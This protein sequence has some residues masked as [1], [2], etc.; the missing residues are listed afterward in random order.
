MSDAVVFSGVSC[1]DED[2]LALFAG[3][4]FAVAA[5]ESLLLAGTASSGKSA[6]LAL[7][8]GGVAPAAGTVEVLGLRPAELPPPELD[9][10]RMRIGYVP[11]RGGLLSN[12]S[13]RDNI[14]LP[15]RYHHD[16]NPAVAEAAIERVHT[17]LDV[18]LLPAVMPADAPLLMRQVAAIARA[19]VLG[20]E[21]LL[22][23]EPGSG[24]DEANAEE[25]WRLLWRVQSETG[26]A[27]LATAADAA[28]ARPLTDRVLHLA[29]RRRVTFRLM[30]GL[31]D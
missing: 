16:A 4:D 2:G 28:A 30:P 23:D 1:A 18:E 31:G 9:R 6:A 27:I 3:I 14:A 24:L 25:L 15:L 22:V 21:L 8:L 12:L 10:L 26:I 29:G 20:P 13:L 19:L 7:C 11:Q 17:L 5:G